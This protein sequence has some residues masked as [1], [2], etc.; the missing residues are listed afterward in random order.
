MGLG[1]AGS[2]PQESPPPP[3]PPGCSRPQGLPMGPSLPVLFRLGSPRC[4]AKVCKVW[5]E[6]FEAAFVEKFLLTKES[7]TKFVNLETS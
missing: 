3:T 4:N 6:I 1:G 7:E 2:R 5:L